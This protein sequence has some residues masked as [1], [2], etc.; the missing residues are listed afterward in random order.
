MVVP[1]F[2]ALAEKPLHGFAEQYR[3]VNSTG[4]AT[5]DITGDNLDEGDGKSEALAEV[6]NTISALTNISILRNWSQLIRLDEE[7][8][9]LLVLNV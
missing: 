2:R 8:W 4:L 9:L 3:E 5:T 6:L 1:S 7:E